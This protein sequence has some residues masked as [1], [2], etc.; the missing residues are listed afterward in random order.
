[1]PQVLAIVDGSSLIHRAFYALPLLTTADGRYTNAVYGF[2]TMLLKLLQEIK[3]DAMA[4]AFDKSRITFRNTDYAQYKAQ[5]KPTPP[6]LTEQ[7]DSVREVLAAFGITCLEQE[8]YEA[9]DIIGTL[10]RCARQ[11]GYETYIVTGDRDALQLIDEHTKV[12]LTKKGISEMELMNLE[13]LAA[14]YGI[15]PEQFIDVKGL[16]GDTSDNIPGVPGVGEVTALKLIKEFGSIENLLANLDKVSGAKLQDKLRSHSDLA[17]L[18]KR[19]AT[20]ACNVPLACD[21]NNL[22]FAPDPEKLRQVFTKFEFKSLLNKLPILFPTAQETVD[23]GEQMPDVIELKTAAAVE[24]FCGAVKAAGSVAVYPLIN[25]QVPDL[26]LCGMALAIKDKVNYVAA[27]A[28]GWELVLSLLRAPE[29]KKITYD[30]K[31]L[32]AACRVLGFDLAGVAFDAEL[33]A[34]LLDP[35]ASAYP[36]TRLTENYLGTAATVNEK[37]P[38]DPRYAGWAAAALRDLYPLMQEKLVAANLDKLYSGIELPLTR[39]L[40]E[41]EMNGIKVDLAALTAMSE[42]MGEQV[43]AL[44]DE[45][46]DLAGKEFNV[47]S[48]KQLGQILFEKLNLPVIKKNKTGY[49]TD[50]EVLEKLSGTHPIIDKLLE[51]RTIVKL[52]STYLDG[53]KGLIHPRTGRLHTSFNQTVTA[54]GRLSSSEPNL[55]NIPVRTEAGRRIRALFIPGEGWDYIMSADY[56]QIE[57]RI[58]AHMSGD[59]HLIAAFMNNEDIHARTAAKIAGIP[60]S[61]VTP[62]MRSRAKAVNFG[63]IYGISD[64]G[65]ARDI[66]ISRQEAAQYIESYFAQYPKVKEYINKTVAQAHRDGY[67]STLFDRR[68]YLPDIRSSNYNKRSFAER[69]A[70]NTPIQGTAADIIKKAMLNVHAALKANNLRSRLLLQVH[71]ELVFEVVKEEVEQVKSIVK[72]AMEQS[73][74]LSVPLTVEIKLGKNWAEAK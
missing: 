13:G 52:K 64:Y 49:S 70:M 50:A 1:M 6:E 22:G 32:Y 39:V 14:K 53:L 3:P 34:Y 72:E 10:A 20:I 43:D 28:P 68:R 24:D 65:L 36:L 21:I 55:Q 67:V 25:G 5:R 62:A 66:G 9:D 27:T 58:L 37:G 42:T 56:S 30:A 7:F 69:T 33:A 54:T 44:L 12:L 46:Y 41:M 16:M 47:N 17:V 15:T 60:L 57:L 31:K 8:G 48:T 2:T 61:E 11:A 59:E 26:V 19:L 38:Q 35:I 71:D 74:K 73:V 40:S 45:I 23:A 18:S 29:I 4:V 63:I 51:Y